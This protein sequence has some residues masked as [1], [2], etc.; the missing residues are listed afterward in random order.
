M[1]RGTLVH[2]WLELIEWLDDELPNRGRP[3]AHALRRAAVA[4]ASDLSS[5]DAEITRFGKLLDQPRIARALSREEYANV[6]ELGFSA[7]IAAE[8][9]QRPLELEVRPELHFAIRQPDGL[10]EGYIDRLVLLRHGERIV[11]ADILDFKTDAMAPRDAKKIAERTEFYRPQIEAYRR[12]VMQ[13]TGLPAE[14][15][16]GRLLFVEGGAV[17]QV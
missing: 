16:M 1:Q 9:A 8:L 17:Q 10:L 2:A 5:L 14:R 12:A 3:D 7:K 11:A 13:I 15:V 6:G 4:A